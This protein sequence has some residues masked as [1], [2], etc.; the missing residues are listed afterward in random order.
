[1]NDRPRLNFVPALRFRVLTRFYDRVVAWAT[2]D[3]A[4]KRRLV[5]LIVASG[6]HSVLDLGCGTGT[7]AI[8]LKRHRPALAVAGLDADAEILDIARRKAD[9]A[10]VAVRFEQG[11]AG[12]VPCPDAAYD[13]IVSTLVFHH[14][15]PAAKHAA[16]AEAR[17][18]LKPGGTLLIADFG[19]AR[20]RW[21]RLAFTLGVRV[22][23]GLA[24]TRDHAA[25]RLGEYLHA[26][27]FESVAL[28]DSMPVLVGQIDVLQARRLNGTP[29]EGVIR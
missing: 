4:L 8:A 14:L 7:L 11:L 20:A 21:R 18:V 10:G 22:L 19:R 3:G 2:R 12:A 13:L 1:M 27:G 6:A 29:W 16:L 26:A 5:D 25:G 9:A 15:L 24:V 17:R 23:D 28:I